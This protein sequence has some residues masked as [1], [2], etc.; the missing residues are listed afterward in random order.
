MRLRRL[1]NSIGLINRLMLIGKI[2]LL[3]T[4]NRVLAIMLGL[5]GEAFELFL[6]IVSIYGLGLKILG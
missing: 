2:L 6:R 1:H 5:M 4:H 3:G